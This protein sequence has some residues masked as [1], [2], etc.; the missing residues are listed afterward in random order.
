METTVLICDDNQAIH[1]ILSTFLQAEGIECVS[2]YSAQ[3]VYDILD[4]QHIDLIIL[5]VMLPSVR[6]TDICKQIR[7]ESSIPIIFLSALGS[8]SDRIIGLKLGADD[9]VTKPFSPYEV[10]LRVQTILKRVSVNQPESN[11]LKFE[12]LTV[13]TDAYLVFV[14]GEKIDLTVKEIDI[15]GFFVKHAGTALSRE[16]ILNSVWGYDYYGDTRAVDAQ[17]KRLRQ[18]LPSEG[19]HFA[20]RSVYGVGYRLERV[21]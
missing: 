20:I 6:G 4:K 21:E 17:I 8:E 3:D 12:E 2:A 15:L 11:R 7:K 5:D 16:R 14:N 18:K 13:D 1:D 10:V 19:V 9:Y